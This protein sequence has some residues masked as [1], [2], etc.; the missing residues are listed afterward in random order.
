MSLEQD[1]G[2]QRRR[3]A[4]MVAANTGFQAEDFKRFEDLALSPQD[5]RH[6]V[7][8]DTCRAGFIEAWDRVYG[9]RPNCRHLFAGFGK[10]GETLPEAE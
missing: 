2:L 4:C 9:A 5:L 7:L 6:I 1:L 8:C 3:A 10:G